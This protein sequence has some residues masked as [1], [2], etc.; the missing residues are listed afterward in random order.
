MQIANSI[1][2][3]K[4]RCLAERPVK[5]NGKK[6][7][8]KA[9][10]VLLNSHATYEKLLHNNKVLIHQNHLTFLVAEI[11]TP[12]KKHEAW[13]Y[14]LFCFSKHVNSLQ[15]RLVFRLPTAGWTACSGWI[16][17]HFPINHFLN[18]EWDKTFSRILIAPV[19]YA[20]ELKLK[21]L[22]LRIGFISASYDNVTKDW[23]SYY[24]YYSYKTTI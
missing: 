11:Y 24:Y 10:K 17:Y 7:H 2:L 15:S 9:L 16:D 20:N 3:R 8:Y 14:E 22:V 23:F 19:T 12:G 5:K 13:V 21:V 18:F 6:K 4:F 1:M